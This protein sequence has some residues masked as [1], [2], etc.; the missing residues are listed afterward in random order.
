MDKFVKRKDR[1]KDEDGEFLSD[2]YETPPEVFQ[3]C[4]DLFNIKNIPI[5]AFANSRNTKAPLFLTRKMNALTM[6]W[7]EYAK[8]QMMEPIFWVQPPYSPGVLGKAIAKAY[9]EAARGATC[10]CLIP[11][12]TDTKWFHKYINELPA[13]NKIFLPG[14]IKHIAPPGLP[15]SNSPTGAS[16]VVLFTKDV[17]KSS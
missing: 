9:E 15:Q 1:P 11:A 3:Q 8:W 10:L 7:I 14:R 5:D 13:S 12:N 16:M 2:Q 6:D 4:K 17:C